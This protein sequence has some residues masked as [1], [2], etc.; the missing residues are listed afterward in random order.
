MRTSRLDLDFT[1]DNS[2]PRCPIL[3]G[4]QH[5][6]ISWAPW[7]D[8]IANGYV[9]VENGR[10][11]RGPRVSQQ[12]I[13]LVGPSRQAKKLSEKKRSQSDFS[14]YWDLETWTVK[15]PETPHLP[16][17]SYTRPWVSHLLLGLSG[18]VVAEVKL[19]HTLPP[20]CTVLR[21]TDW[22]MQLQQAAALPPVPS[23]RKIQQQPNS[24]WFRRKGWGVKSRLCP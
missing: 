4:T 22:G 10:T 5:F 20:Y 14:K 24:K 6:S 13:F 21:N 18:S 19:H 3:P 9:F 7:Q 1:R 15:A 11:P 23:G 17:Q 12:E 8:W 16:S 2:C